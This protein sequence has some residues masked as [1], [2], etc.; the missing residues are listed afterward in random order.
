M[1]KRV[2]P[3]LDWTSGLDTIGLTQTAFLV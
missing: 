3:S 2:S 1:E